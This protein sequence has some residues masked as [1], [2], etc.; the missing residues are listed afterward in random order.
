MKRPNLTQIIDFNVKRRLERELPQVLTIF[1]SI[2]VQLHPHLD[3]AEA[4]VVH[5]VVK[6][7]IKEVE[8]KIKVLQKRLDNNEQS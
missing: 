5:E 1:K 6:D 4:Y 7:G 8:A 3:N 2:L